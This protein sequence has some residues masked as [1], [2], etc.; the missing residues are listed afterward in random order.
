MDDNDNGWI[1]KGRRRELETLFY[2]TI[3][4][5]CGIPS[6]T[7][8]LQYGFEEFR[9]SVVMGLATPSFEL[10]LTFQKVSVA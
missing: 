10:W 6:F 2:S 1:R 3:T 9:P 7:R 4:L 8:L 5:L